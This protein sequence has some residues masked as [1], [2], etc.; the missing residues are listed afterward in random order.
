MLSCATLNVADAAASARR[1]ADWFSYEI[2]DSG[3][4]DGGLAASWGAPD[5]EGRP[6]Q[7]L[8]P[9]SGKAIFIR[10]VEGRPTRR[11]PPFGALGWMAMEICVEDV[12][13]AAAHMAGSPFEVIGAPGA[14]GELATIQAMQVLGPDGDVV[15]LTEVKSKVPGNGLPRAQTPIDYIFIMVIGCLD[16]DATFAWLE[17][18]LGVVPR[19]TMAIKYGHINRAFGRPADTLVKLRSAQ[20]D[21]LVQLEMSELPAQAAADRD[22]PG[23]FPSG[24]AMTTASVPDLDAVPGP[25]ITP[26]RARPGPLYLGRRAGAMLAP[27]GGLLEII[28]SQVGA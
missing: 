1:Y 20:R 7:L 27:D 9:A 25:W 15:Y 22:P 12:M 19:M 3:A 17:R 26:P 18:Q 10:F 21:G 23:A 16:S 14:V 2:V 28:E 24:I 8:R 6:F 13:A 5:L 11:R 4:V